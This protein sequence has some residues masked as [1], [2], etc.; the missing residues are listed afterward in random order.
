MATSSS[1]WITRL[2]QLR[3]GVTEGDVDAGVVGLELLKQGQEL[4]RSD[5][6]HH[7]YA[8]GGVL[9]LGEQLGSLLCG[10]GLRQDFL[11]VPPHRPAQLGE[12]SVLAFPVEQRAPELSFEVL[13]GAGQ[14]WLRNV[15]LL[16]GAGEVEGLAKGL[17]VFYLV[18]L[19]GD[20]PTGRSIRPATCD[21]SRRGRR[22]RPPANGDGRE[23]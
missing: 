13:D 16:G 18:V 2:E 22:R 21:A 6:A 19:H 1:P 7:S 23:P 8:E 20:L 3:P 14:A 10:L 5:R 9:E 17:E 11:Q 12:M 4:F 15:A